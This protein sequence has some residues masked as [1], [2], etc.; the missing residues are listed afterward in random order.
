VLDQI[1]Y[2]L[3]HERSENVKSFVYTTAKTLVNSNIPSEK[4][5]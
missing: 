4:E 1:T 2:A 5:L 3:L